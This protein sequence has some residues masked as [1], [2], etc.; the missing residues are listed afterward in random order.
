[1]PE[2]IEEL[3]PKHNK[4]VIAL[5]KDLVR[6]SFV[7]NNL[8]SEEGQVNDPVVRGHVEAHTE[9]VGDSVADIRHSFALPPRPAQSAA[10]ANDPV[11]LMSQAQSLKLLQGNI[12]KFVSKV[13]GLLD[14]ISGQI[15]TDA[16]QSLKELSRKLNNDLCRTS[17]M[18]R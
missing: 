3:A 17:Y 5:C 9:K 14:E 6:H 16:R 15:G 10:G 18:M 7:M 2:T 13:T 8:V 12:Q 11:D 1:M 4:Q